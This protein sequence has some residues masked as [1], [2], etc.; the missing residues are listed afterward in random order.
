MA[1]GSNVNGEAIYGTRPWTHFGEGGSRGFR[2]TT[3]GNTLYAIALSWPENEAVIVSL[4]STNAFAGRI[5]TVT[6]L[7]HKGALA[8]SQDE[9]G[10]K[11]KMPAEKPCDYAWTYKITGLKLY[12]ENSTTR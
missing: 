7:G 5:K 4:A 8:F 3:R 2:F 1:D 6:L 12:P 11:I 9:T 10:L